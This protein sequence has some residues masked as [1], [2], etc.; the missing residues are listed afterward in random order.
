MV[1]FPGGFGTLDEMFETLT[2]SQTGKLDRSVF[3]LLYGAEYWREIINFDALV[4][5]GMIAPRDAALMRFADD[6]RE[7]L[8]LLQEALPVSREKAGPDLAESV[9]T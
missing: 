6:P 3:V 5:H 2:L 7:A 8:R 1:I 4:K 9:A